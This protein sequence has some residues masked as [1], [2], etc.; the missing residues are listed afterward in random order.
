MS[1]TGSDSVGSAHT[2]I[3]RTLFWGRSGGT[4]EGEV[5][6]CQWPRFAWL[7]E[8]LDMDRVA[9]N[10]LGGLEGPKLLAT[11]R[12]RGKKGVIFRGEP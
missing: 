7:V 3:K 10:L 2:K 11:N 1:F 12:I 5:G 6:I 9:E 4:L 8:D